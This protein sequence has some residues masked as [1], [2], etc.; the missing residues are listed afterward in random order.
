MHEYLTGKAVLVTGGTGSIG[1]E[2]VRQVLGQSPSVVRIFSRDETK[3]YM[4]ESALGRRSD[5]RYLVGD[6]REK[7]RLRRAMKGIDVV[8]HAAAL[9]Q[10]PSCEYNPFE[11]VKTNVVGTQNV[12]DAALEAGVSRVIAISTD[13]AINPTS[14]MGATKLLAERLVAT[15]NAWA[16]E[17]AF[18]CVRFGNVLNSRGS[19]VPM[20]KSQIERG[21]PVT[22]TDEEMTRFMMPIS[23]AVELT[24]EAGGIA[25]GGEIFICKMPSVRIRDLLDVLISEYAPT[26]GVDPGAVKVRT[27]GVRPGEKMEEELVTREELPH[28]TQMKRLLV[29]HP[30]HA[31]VF[32]EAGSIPEALYRSS[33]ADCLDLPAI[34]GLLREAGALGQHH[35]GV[36]LRVH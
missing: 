20:A 25:E 8:F 18:A 4:L 22:L 17:T 29:V 32:S 33:R 11:A 5:L 3:Q 14:T 15:A 27:I 30:I 9:K 10:V 12:I 31:G 26:V 36:T 24:L 2:I 16:T 13:K 19:L 23:Q 21:G 7:D 28:T 35:S 34:T 1:S 6:I